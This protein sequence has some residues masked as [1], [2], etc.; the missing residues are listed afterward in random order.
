[1]SLAEVSR[2]LLAPVE[3]VTVGFT[4]SAAVLKEAVVS[5]QSSPPELEA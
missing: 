3:F 5:A 4:G 2:T 1:M